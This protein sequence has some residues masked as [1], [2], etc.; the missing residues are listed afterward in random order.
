MRQEG[1]A[2]YYN[3]PKRKKRKKKGK[4]GEEEKMLSQLVAIVV[5]HIAHECELTMAI[6]VN[7]NSA[8]AQAKL[9]QLGVQH[10]FT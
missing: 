2:Y 1:E 9:T 6:A 5:S 7:F 4:R 10:C 3:L 8:K